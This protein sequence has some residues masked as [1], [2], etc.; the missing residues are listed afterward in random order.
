MVGGPIWVNWV[1][2][3]LLGLVCLSCLARLTIYRGARIRPAGTPHWHEDVSQLVM[4]IGM[5]AM[6]LA[7]LGA[8]PKAMWLLVFL[9]E[10]AIFAVLLFRRQDTPLAPTDSWQYVH[11]LMA[12]LAMAY[13]VLATGTLARAAH[14]MLLPSLASSFAMYFIGYTIWSLVRV[15]RGT[16]AVAGGGVSTVLG[17]PRVVEGCRVVMGAGMVYM[18]LAAM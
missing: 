5:I 17:K 12:G 14:P 18:F 2:S 15:K 3:S 13:V 16:L 11:H 9:G 6:L 10:A 7:W 4:G 8:I 1:L